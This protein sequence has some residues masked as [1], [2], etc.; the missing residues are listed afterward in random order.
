MNKLYKM[1]VL[2]SLIEDGELKMKAGLEVIGL[3]FSGF[4]KN[5]PRFQKDLNNKKHE[6]W[7]DWKLDRFMREAR[8]NPVKFLSKRK[9]FNYDEVNKEFFLNPK[10]E[11]FIDQNISKHFK[12]IVNLR[13]LRYYNRRLK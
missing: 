5:N 1:P 7:Q 12:D 11:K 8:I 6:G 3:S 4:Y 9:F 2:E 13:Q 10:L